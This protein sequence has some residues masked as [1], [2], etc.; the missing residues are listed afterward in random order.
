LVGV[1]VGVGVGVELPD[2][3]PDEPDGFGAG[4]LL[5]EGFGLV[6]ELGEPV[7]GLVLPLVGRALPEP[8]FPPCL[9]VDFLPSEGPT[10]VGAPGLAGGM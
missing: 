3:P 7:A 2:D 1:G 10:A 9:G 8:P 4:A 6:E 5:P